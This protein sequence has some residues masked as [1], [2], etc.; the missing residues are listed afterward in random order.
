MFA[1]LY[2]LLNSSALLNPVQSY[3]PRSHE[4]TDMQPFA[5]HYFQRCRGSFK[6]LSKILGVSCPP[7]LHWYSQFCM[8]C[9]IAWHCGTLTISTHPHLHEYTD[10]QPFAMHHFWRGRASLKSL[11]INFRGELS[12]ISTCAA[13]QLRTVEPCPVIS[14]TRTSIHR[15]ASFCN[16]LF[17]RMQSILEKFMIHL[18]QLSTVSSSY[19]R[20]STGMLNSLHVNKYATSFVVHITS[21]LL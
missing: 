16:A 13:Q 9:L 5:M 19:V 6:S 17:S 18:T 12:T 2:V 8:C 20:W 7:L 15:Y 21:P 11:C 4:Y 14:P 1:I 3:H 10:V